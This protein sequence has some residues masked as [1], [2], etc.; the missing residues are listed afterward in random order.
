MSC[1]TP[2]VA[3]NNGGTPE[4]VDHLSNGFIAKNK[5]PESLADGINYS[6]EHWDT[7]SPMSRKKVLT[8]YKEEIIAEKYKSLYN[9]L[10]KV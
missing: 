10:L 9:E 8:S 5:D 1:G 3:F 4:M 2:V 6:I 7:F